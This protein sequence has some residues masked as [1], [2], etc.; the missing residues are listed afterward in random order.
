MTDLAGFLAAASV[1]AT[2]FAL[3]PDYRAGLLA[4][5]GLIPSTS[6]EASDALLTAAED[7]LSRVN[8]LTDISTAISILHRLP[9]G[10]ALAPTSDDALQATVDELADLGP[11]ITMHSH[12]AGDDG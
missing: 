6:G 5:D 10:G 11:D 9:L 1:D 4:V 3:R 7:G 2:V 12:I 8:R